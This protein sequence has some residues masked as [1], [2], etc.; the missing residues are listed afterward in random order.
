MAGRFSIT[1]GIVSRGSVMTSNIK[2]NSG[3]DELSAGV[4]AIVYGLLAVCMVWASRNE[5]N[6]IVIPLIGF[7]TLDFH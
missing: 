7:R 2:R 4:S 1:A 6:C 3:L 5:L